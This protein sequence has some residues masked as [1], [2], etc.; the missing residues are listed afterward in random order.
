MSIPFLRILNVASIQRF[1]LK[2]N[3]ALFTWSIKKNKI[4]KKTWKTN[5]RFQCKPQYIGGGFYF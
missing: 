4:N 5:S 3:A 1:Y 2:Y